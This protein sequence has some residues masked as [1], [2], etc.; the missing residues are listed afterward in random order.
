LS[1]TSSSR[2]RTEEHEVLDVGDDVCDVDVLNILYVEVEDDIF[3]LEDDVLDLETSSSMS[4]TENLVL[5]L[6]NKVLEVEDVARKRR[7]S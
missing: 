4:R 1:R 3:D 2:S 7:S 6:E 5:D